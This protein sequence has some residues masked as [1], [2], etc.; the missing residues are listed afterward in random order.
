MY[1]GIYLAWYFV[2]LFIYLFVFIHSCIRL[3]TCVHIFF[4]FFIY[5]YIFC[6]NVRGVVLG[7]VSAI[8]ILIVKQ[9]I[10]WCSNKKR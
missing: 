9:K 3:F 5:I 8:E 1:L 2:C 10:D 7:H 4:I 6:G